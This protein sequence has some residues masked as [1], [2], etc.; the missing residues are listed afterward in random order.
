MAISWVE[1]NSSRSAT[2]ARLGRRGRSVYRKSY[3]L[4]GSAD[5]VE[6]HADVNRTLTLGG[7]IFE[8]PGAGD[9]RLQ[10]ES[11]TLEYLGGDAWQL[12]VDYA[13]DG[14]ADDE[15]QAAPLR[16]SRS[17]DTTNGTA[18]ITQSPFYSDDE[19]QSFADWWAGEPPVFAG[20][21]RYPATGPTGTV[22]APS[23]NGAIGV[24]GDRINGVDI[25]VPSLS[26][27]ESYDV[28]STYVSDTYIRK[29]SA[30]SGTV[31]DAT[32]R[33][34]RPGEVLFL[35]SSGSQDW[36]EQK[37]DGPWSLTFRFVA[38][39]N[40]DGTTL[41]RLKVGDLDGIEKEGHEYL[42][43]EYE[44]LATDTSFIKRPKF[45]YVNQVYAKADFSLLGIGVT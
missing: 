26:W 42:W 31:N 10:A 40:A 36:D 33:G 23:Q 5:D 2:I 29:I 32:F 37:G 18:H 6:V 8:Y 19:T 35:G 14:G 30:M 41:P 1:D 20:E 43:I 3:K 44:N 11:Y 7:L 27:S 28:P 15:D 25:V 22:L 21:K 38:S 9:Q 13:K 16:R 45:V 12:T 4:F 17:F 39:P 24:D 34:F